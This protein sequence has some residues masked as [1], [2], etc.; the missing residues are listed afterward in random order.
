LVRLGD[1]VLGSVGQLH[2]D[3]AARWD[4][5][6]EVLV[7]E[8]SIETLLTQP[9][10]AKR[11]RALERFPAVSRD[12]SVVC[13]AAL[14]ARDIAERIQGAA[15]DLLKGLAVVD[16]YVGTPVPEGRVSLTFALRF[17]S[18]ERTLTSEEVQAAV[19]R[20]VEALRSIGAEIRSA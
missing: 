11:Y 18:R 5:R 7:A 19:E 15:G 3:L 20:A 12:L 9:L 16:R 6:E 13:D 1:E 8:I 2:P 14:R 17:Q 10:A 4:L